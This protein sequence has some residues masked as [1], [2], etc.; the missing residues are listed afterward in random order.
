MDTT[1][2]PADEDGPGCPRCGGKYEI[3]P[4][5]QF[6]ICSYFSEYSMLSK[7]LAEPKLTTRNVSAATPAR[8]LWTVCWLV[9]P[10]TRIFTVE[11]AMARS[12][13]QRDMDLLEA[14]GSFKAE[15][16]K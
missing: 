9:M 11:V 12:L 6:T 3:S 13:E 15:T 1:V 7:C 4:I 5:L 10:L 2:I 14:P 16:C 8:D